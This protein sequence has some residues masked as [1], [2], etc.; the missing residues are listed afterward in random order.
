VPVGRFVQVNAEITWSNFWHLWLELQWWPSIWD[1]REAHDGA[2]V[3]KAEQWGGEVYAE[4]N[5]NRAWTVSFFGDLHNTW[6]GFQTDTELSFAVRPVDRL[7]VRLT[8]SLLRV[9]GDPRWV[10]TSGAAYRFG[11]QDATA[12]GVTLQSTITFTPRVTLQLYAQ[13]FFASVDYGAMYDVRTEGAKPWVPL[14]A[15]ST[16]AADPKAFE[17]REAVLNMNVVFRWEYLPGALIYVAYTRSQNGAALD[18]S[19]QRP[20]LD[21]ASLGHVSAENVFLVKASYNFSR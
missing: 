5:P 2:R 18:P 10:E 9:T 20:R 4:T 11:L 12:L 6:R 21:F 3:Q 17:E 13:L 19:A 8:P 16:S 15:L 1:N 14:S 7:E